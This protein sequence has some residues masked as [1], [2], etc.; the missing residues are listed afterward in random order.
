MSIWFFLAPLYGVSEDGPFLVGF[1]GIL[2]LGLGFPLL[3]NFTQRL[4]ST[5]IV[6]VSEGG[7]DHRK[8]NDS[9]E[10]SVLFVPWDKVDRVTVGYSKQSLDHVQVQFYSNRGVITI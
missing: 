6:I 1:A 2:I 3:F 5:S 9:I 4:N 10:W 7:I 8:F